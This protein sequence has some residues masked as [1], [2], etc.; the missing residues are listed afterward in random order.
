[1]KKL[2]TL[3]IVIVVGVNSFSQ[4][5]VSP[6]W[7]L[8]DLDGNEHTLYDYLDEGKS[9]IVNIATTSMD[10]D[11]GASFLYFSEGHLNDLYGVH[12]PFG[13][14]EVMVFIIEVDPT[15]TVADLNGTGPNTLGDWASFSNC[16]IINKD[17]I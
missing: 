4:E 14:D 13:T 1:M 17:Y 7:T 11:G 6:N 3:L 8:W 10:T 15:T 2:F 9:V 12:G 16:P 5:L